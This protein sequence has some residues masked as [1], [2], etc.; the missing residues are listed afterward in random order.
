LALDTHWVDRIEK[1]GNAVLIS[2]PGDTVVV[3]DRFG[4]QP[5]DYSRIQFAD[6]NQGWIPDFELKDKTN[7]KLVKHKKFAKN[8]LEDPMTRYKGRMASEDGH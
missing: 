1:E 8:T 5:S 4:S 3:I 7:K 2:S 6:G